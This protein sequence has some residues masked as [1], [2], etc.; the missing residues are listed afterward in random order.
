MRSLVSKVG[1]LFAICA[2]FF[3]APS[4]ARADGSFETLVIGESDS[5]TLL[6]VKSQCEDLVLL[7]DWE[8]ETCALVDASAHCKCDSSTNTTEGKCIKW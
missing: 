6:C 2:V 4:A 5:S 3:L 8:V 1:L 7:K